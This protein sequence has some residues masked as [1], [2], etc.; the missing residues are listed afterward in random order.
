VTREPA[1]SFYESIADRF[2]GMDHPADLRRRL[3][4]VFDECLRSASL[5][6]ARLL[7]A[8]CGYGPFSHAAARRGAAV[9]SVDIGTRLVGRA[10]A[11]SGSRGVVSD[12]CALAFRDGS[13]DVVVSSEMIEHTPTPEQAVRELGRVLR[14]GGLLVVTTPN[15]LWQAP[16]RMA[17]RLRIRPFQGIEN[18]LPWRRLERA[19][20]E[21]GL[22]I[23]RHVGF[24]PWPF[25]LGMTATARHAEKLA[26]S[27]SGRLMVNQAILCRKLATRP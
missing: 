24:H 17:S 11:R 13:F 14:A 16:V 26:G 3:D 22:E 8:G 27:W 5:D 7:D 2:E 4:L 12:A 19:C 15:R 10:A 9:I 18:F 21:S 20:V 6:G 1:S 23:L 25:Q